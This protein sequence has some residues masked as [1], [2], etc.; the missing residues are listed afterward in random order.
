MSTKMNP[1]A[2]TNP[3]TRQQLGA[4]YHFGDKREA[5]LIALENGQDAPLVC[6]KCGGQAHYKNTI[7]TEKCIDC[8]AIKIAYLTDTAGKYMA[9]GHGGWLA[10]WS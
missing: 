9:D 6:G 1:Y 5:M 3:W 2:S 10:K 8:G 4:D 7:G